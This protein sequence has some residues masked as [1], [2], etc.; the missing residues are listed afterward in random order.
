MPVCV[1]V[2]GEQSD[3]RAGVSPRTSVFLSHYRSTNAPYS[4]AYRSVEKD[5]WAKPGSLPA[6]QCFFFFQP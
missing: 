1:L 4:S 3:N 5:N 2:C 6:K